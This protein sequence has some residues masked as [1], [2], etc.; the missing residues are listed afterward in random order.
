MECTKSTFRLEITWSTIL[1]QGTVVEMFGDREAR[2]YQITA[3]NQVIQALKDGFRRICVVLPTGAGKSLTS[4]LVFA[5]PEMREFLKI[6]ADQ[7]IRI[8]FIAHRQRLLSQAEE[9]Y[10]QESGIM[11]LR[12]SSASDI[13]ENL[14]FDIVCMDECHHESTVSIQLKLEKISQVPFIG[15]TATQVRSDSTLIKFDKFVEPLTREEAVEQGF[16]AKSN[17]F[18][19]IDSPSREHSDM[20][21]DIIELKKDIVGQAMVFVRTKAEALKLTAAI[22]KLGYVARSLV[23]ISEKVLNGE[24]KSFEN[25]EYQFAVSCNKLGEGVDI[26]GCESVII[27]R[28]LQSYPLLTQIIGRSARPDCE[29]NVFEIINPLSNSNLD[30]TALISPEVHEV[31]Y[32]VRGQWRSNIA[33]A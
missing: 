26:K 1:D 20:V 29:S 12:Q 17:L 23:D 13:P 28:T 2:H 19:F 10:A 9:L 6:P 21:L 27:G 18:S 33:R 8:L 11:I 24:L 4:G 14:K 5:C 22:N 32:K 25:K 31:W 3:K 15:L 30:A 7:P 16:L